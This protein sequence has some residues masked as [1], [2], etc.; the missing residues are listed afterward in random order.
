MKQF[1]PYFNLNHT[2]NPSVWDS[3]DLVYSSGPEF[4]SRLEDRLS[5]LKYLVVFL[6]LSRQ[7]V[8]HVTARYI[9]QPREFARHWAIC[10]YRLQ[11]TVCL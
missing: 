4:E 6:S 2:E 9:G 3:T 8:L 10:K 7:T 5:R 11:T 1:S